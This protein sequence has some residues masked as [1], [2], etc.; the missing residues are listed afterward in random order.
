MIILRICPWLGSNNF[1]KHILW[2]ENELIGM[3]YGN[4][5]KFMPFEF[6]HLFKSSGLSK[7]TYLALKN[8]KSWVKCG[9]DK[10]I[11]LS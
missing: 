7:I 8:K 3:G 5:E 6:N 10:L 11:M 4:R 2:I 1:G 9:K